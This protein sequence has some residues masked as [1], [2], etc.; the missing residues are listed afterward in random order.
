MSERDHRRSPGMSET[1]RRFIET[2][3]EAIWILDDRR[4]TL[5]ANARLSETLGR[6]PEMFADMRAEE[7]VLDHD[8]ERFVTDVA[9]VLGGARRTADVALLHADG[10]E[11]WLTIRMTPIELAPDGPIGVLMMASDV[12]ARLRTE[13]AL[14]R[15]EARY[16]A[17]VETAPDHILILTGDGRIEF[18]SRGLGDSSVESLIGTSFF[19]LVATG[20]RERARLA[21]LR[22]LSKSAVVIEEL[23]VCCVEK[24]LRRHVCRLR[25][26]DD[27]F[28]PDRLVGFL[29]DVTEIKRVQEE[30]HASQT[31]LLQAQRMEAVGRLAGGLAHDFNNILSVVSGC[32]SFV[33]SSLRSGDPIHDDVQRIL[34]ASARAE[35][36]TRQLLA[37]SRRQ[38]LRPTAV[39]LGEVVRG[40]HRML[41]RLL[42]EHVLLR[43]DC[44]GDVPRVR[45][46]VGQLEHVVVNLCTNARD[47]MGAGGTI[48]ITTSP[49]VVD[50]ELAAREGVTAGSY[51]AL[52]VSDTGP[53]LED[54]A[55]ARVFEPF[56]RGDAPNDNG[57]L[58]ASVY[59][60]V[61]QSG[62]TVV[63][64]SEPGRGT[65]FTV[66][67][68]AD[69][70]QPRSA[71]PTAR[72]DA[73]ILVVEDDPQVRY[74]IR[75]ALD[76]A[77]YRTLAAESPDEA[78]GIVERLEGRIDL[79]VTDV[80]MPGMSGTQLAR[81]LEPLQPAMRVLYVTGYLDDTTLRLG[82]G[83]TDAAIV[84]KPFAPLA[85]VRRIAELLEGRN[86]LLP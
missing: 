68:P 40:L 67:L 62:G 83:E 20:D 47:W 27:R 46:D 80:V 2:A 16:R 30:L 77:G 38:V 18:I 64:S 15:S 11:I 32:A 25:R 60:I 34:E 35:T 53:G 14:R 72:G 85:L 44:G 61:R 58:L 65:T 19:N 36:L 28:G 55:L 84:H 42:G 37:F 23:D 66:L 51:A 74:V 73:T 56:F 12:T 4:T 50:D 76:A 31:R 7:L 63:A 45:V 8:R 69:S 43:V 81:C 33:A 17:L 86:S 59:G 3:G 71:R 41:A 49:R 48:T 78:I 57:L 54:D 79:L 21:V 13:N 22:A 39:E 10:S 29:T 26:I 82:L 24:L 1:L 5:F 52:S 9:D 6:A 70:A 75:R